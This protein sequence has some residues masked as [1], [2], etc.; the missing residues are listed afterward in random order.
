MPTD[1]TVIAARVRAMLATEGPYHVA[2]RYIA[3]ADL[4]DRMRWLA[5]ERRV[6][7]DARR[8]AHA[9]RHASTAAVPAVAADAA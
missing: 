3:D 1:R 7:D 8:A 6:D 9:A 5:A 2:G 4:A